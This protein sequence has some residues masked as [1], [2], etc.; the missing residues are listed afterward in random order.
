MLWS[1]DDD[2]IGVTIADSEHPCTATLAEDSAGLPVEAT[3]GHPLLDTR[4][5]NNVDPVP[6]LKSLDD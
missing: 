2:L 6:D 1:C 4:V 5:D 3:V